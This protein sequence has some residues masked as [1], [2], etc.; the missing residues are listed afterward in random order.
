[1]RVFM[2]VVIATLAASLAGAQQTAESPK[3]GAPGAP[4]FDVYPMPSS[5]AD[6]DNSGEPSI[7]IPWNTNHV[8][9]QAFAHTHRAAFDDNATP[10][11]VHW[12]DV[13][14]HTTPI[15]I[16]PILYGDHATNRVWAG[17][18]AGPCALMAF[19]DD[20][21]ATWSPVGNACT[22]AQFDHESIGAGAWGNSTV[23]PARTYGDGVYYCSQGDRP[24]SGIVTPSQHG[25]A[26]VTSLDGGTSWLPLVE[27][28]GG[29]GLFHGHIKVSPSGFVVVPFA[30]CGGT[31]G[32][33]YSDDSGT[34][35]NSRTIPG[36]TPGPVMGFDPS[37]DFSHSGWLTYAQGD[38]Q[39]LYVGMSKDNG[40]SW[41]TLGTTT[42]GVTPSTWLNLSAA[43][44]DPATGQHLKYAN[45]VDVAA[46]DDGRAAIAFQGTVDPRG[47]DP[48]KCTAASDPN[49]WQYYLAQT[50]DAGATWTIHRIL[51]DP[52]QVGGVWDGGGGQPCRNLLDFADMQI[53]SYGRVVI[54]FADGCTG[55]CAQK[56]ADHVAHGS[57][58]P[59]GADSRSAHG[60][61]LRQT[62]GRGLFAKDDVASPVTSPPPTTTSA[63]VSPGVAVALLIVAL[64]ALAR[65]R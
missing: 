58:P 4:H 8:F 12:D 7:G 22:A 34:T 5:L 57:A 35:F 37:V 47:A 36:S 56:W 38:E 59:K 13:T 52:V 60:T 61:I 49:V 14:P 26:C 31:S 33:G 25:A 28:N 10:P 30:D 53:D 9:F 27:V 20:D 23:A 11:A 6:A 65:R 17:G 2:L 63:K 43:Y 50:F 46:G 40:K 24:D 21:G 3:F 41:E 15:N 16:D 44:T 62:T 42:P 64:A 45:F 18:L 54:G 1:M 39:G 19:S 51:D 29:C 48:F 55:A 32:F